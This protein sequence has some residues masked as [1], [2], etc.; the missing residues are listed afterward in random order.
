M[1]KVGQ[2]E[3]VTVQGIINPVP[4]GDVDLPT[5]HTTSSSCDREQISP[6]G[7]GALAPVVEGNATSTQPKGRYREEG[8]EK[9]RGS[10]CSTQPSDTGS[11]SDSKSDS[12]SKNNITVMEIPEKEEVHKMVDE[13]SDSIAKLTTHKGSCLVLNDESSGSNGQAKRLYRRMLPQG[14]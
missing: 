1:K 2:S 13:V 8:T 14:S 7:V 5:S 12:E 11:D 4:A 10:S 6:T 9:L 3:K